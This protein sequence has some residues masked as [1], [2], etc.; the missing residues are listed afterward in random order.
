MS[1]SVPSGSEHK[2]HALWELQN[3]GSDFHTQLQPLNIQLRIPPAD[4]EIQ[5]HQA[6]EFL[7]L[8]DDRWLFVHCCISA[9]PAETQKQATEGMRI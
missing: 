2:L 7:A 1:T 3:K 4:P 6:S 9:K 8:A 5:Q